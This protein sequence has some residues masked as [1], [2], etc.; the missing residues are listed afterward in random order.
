[1]DTASATQ[2]KSKVRI[3]DLAGTLLVDGNSLLLGMALRHLKFQGKGGQLS[4]GTL[5]IGPRRLWG[6][7]VPLQLCAKAYNQKSI[8]FG[9]IIEFISIKEWTKQLKP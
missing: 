4:S 1:M 6:I 5:R 8:E 3:P 9:F 2:K 7:S